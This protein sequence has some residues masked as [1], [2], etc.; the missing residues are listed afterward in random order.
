VLNPVAPDAA[1][2]I[3]G[4]R[5]A[6]VEI[7]S[8]DF[9]GRTPTPNVRAIYRLKAGGAQKLDDVSIG[10][11]PTPGHYLAKVDAQ[12]KGTFQFVFEIECAKKSSRL[13]STAFK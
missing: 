13:S 10:I 7:F 6:T 1:L 12:D 4:A 8:C 3:P 2:R 9:A 5:R 11:A